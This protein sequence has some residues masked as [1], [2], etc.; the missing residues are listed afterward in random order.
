MIFGD[1]PTMRN[2]RLVP[3]IH[4]IMQ[5]G[6]LYM[7]VMHNPVMWVD[8]SG[9]FA[10]P[11][12]IIP[13]PVP[14]PDTGIPPPFFPTFEPMQP[15]PGF[16]TLDDIIRDLTNMVITSPFGS[17]VR[18][19]GNIAITPVD[20]VAG[21]PAIITT[22]ANKTSVPFTLATLPSRPG[23]MQMEVQRGQAPRDVVRVDPPHSEAQWARPHV[24]YRDGTSMNN[25]G[26]IH[27]SRGGTPNPSN[28]IREWLNRHGWATTPRR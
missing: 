7:F 9:L 27:D 25:D 18:N 2:D 12:I 10:S 20:R 22:P 24:H 6:N 13:I 14:R 21:N 16:P 8:P 5:S 28:E 26:S 23:T 15:I 3:S 4:A 19:F 1:S 11:S 17:A